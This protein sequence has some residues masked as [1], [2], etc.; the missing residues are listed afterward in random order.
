VA[1]AEFAGSMVAIVTPFRDGEVDVAAFGE[2]VEWHLASG[3]TAIVVSGTTGEAATL[4]MEEKE[5]L[6][7]RAVEICRGRCL[8]VAGTGT[9][10][11]WSTVECTRAAVGWGVDGL[12][13]VT[14]YYNKPTQ[15]GLLAHF[16]AVAQVA[17]GCPIIAYD[18]PGRT[19]VT[20]AEETCH[21]LARI[22]G[23]SALKDATH[24]VERAA[25]LARETPLTILSGDDAL[26]L[27]LLRGGARGV[28]SVAANIVPDRM[29][30]LCAEQD[31]AL[32]ES[33]APLFAALFVESNPIPLKF[34]LS[35][36]GRIKNE[37]RLPL[38]PLATEHETTV[39][40]AL[41]DATL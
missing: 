13:V 26:T 25:R 14:P 20:I 1:A 4:R 28:I 29:A 7:R 17:N 6:C 5:A 15:A 21:R 10:A 38:V 39:R 41:R 12:L 19:G 40:E 30:R 27:T 31:A 33:L 32:H 3:T 24:D 11:T 34:A 18:V 8:V 2:L 35:E 16:E 9:N 23:V 36:T 37:L 22:P